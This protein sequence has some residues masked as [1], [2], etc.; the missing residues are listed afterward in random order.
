MLIL[1]PNGPAPTTASFVKVTSGTVIKTMLQVKPKV[2]CKIVE[3]G[4]SGSAF[5]AAAPGTVELIETDVAATVTAHVNGGISRLDGAALRISDITTDYIEV[6]TAATGYTGSAEGSITST[7]MLDG[8]QLIAPTTQFSKQIPL[9]QETIIP[10][11]AFARIRVHFAG[12]IDIIC[13]MKIALL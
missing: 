3:W 8:P 11:G 5:A 13:W 1:I 4:F 12:A 10:K 7:R 9:A 6:G 2:E